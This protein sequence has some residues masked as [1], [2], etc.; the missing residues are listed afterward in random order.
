M[1]TVLGEKYETKRRLAASRDVTAIHELKE[2]TQDHAFFSTYIRFICDV[3]VQVLKSHL[4]A[5]MT[6]W[7]DSVIKK[8][9]RTNTFYIKTRL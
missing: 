1:F 2:L 3:D 7:Y 4:I 8:R 6:G 9:G 5:V